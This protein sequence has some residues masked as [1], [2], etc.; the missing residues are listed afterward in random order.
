MLRRYSAA[1]GVPVLVLVEGERS[2]TQR[3][4]CERVGEELVVYGVGGRVMCVALLW[5]RGPLGDVV[6]GLSIV[7]V[8]GVVLLAGG[9]AGAC[10]VF[11]LFLKLNFLG[12]SKL[13]FTFCS[14]SDSA[15]MACWG[16]FVSDS[17]FSLHTPFSRCSLSPCL[18]DRV[19]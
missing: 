18:A 13:F 9:G 14:F 6:S 10:T 12:G 3:V 17:L 4:R 5:E 16:V 7:V 15:F 1:K 8:V 19:F 11:F 2:T